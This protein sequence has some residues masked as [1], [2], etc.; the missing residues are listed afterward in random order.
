MADEGDQAGV[1]CRSSSRASTRTQGIGAAY[2][3]DFTRFG[4]VQA[5]EIQL[6]RPEPMK[7]DVVVRF[8]QFLLVASAIILLVAML[9]H[10]SANTPGCL[11]DLAWPIVHVGESVGGIPGVAGYAASEQGVVGLTETARPGGR[12]YRRAG[13]HNTS[14]YN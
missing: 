4:D 11:L 7:I 1:A 6:D 12:D 2:C 9:F 5:S 14:R 13:Q 8:G 10:P 3:A